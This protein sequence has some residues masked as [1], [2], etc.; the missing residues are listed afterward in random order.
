MP[1]VYRI[2]SINC[3]NTLLNKPL[4]SSVKFMCSID[5]GGVGEAPR[6][7][8]EAKWKKVFLIVLIIF[9]INYSFITTIGSIT[10][11]LPK[12]RL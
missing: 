9:L 1:I 2:N 11:L 8:I 4:G 12:L 3:D 6:L 5:F 7:S 10:I